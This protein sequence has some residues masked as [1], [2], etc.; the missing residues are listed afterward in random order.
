MAAMRK[1]D[2]TTEQLVCVEY[3]GHDTLFIEAPGSG[4]SFVLSFRGHAHGRTAG[5]TVQFATFTNAVARAA[6]EMDQDVAREEP[7]GAERIRLAIST[8]DTAVLTHRTDGVIPLDPA[9]YHAELSPAD[10]EEFLSFE[11]TLLYVAITRARHMLAM[12]CF[13]TPSRFL[14]EVGPATYEIGTLPSLRERLFVRTKPPVRRDR[15]LIEVN[16]R[17]GVWLDT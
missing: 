14:Q 7:A 4:K 12:T 5:E 1:A 6:K 11:R 10:E 17:A 16:R 15:F 9:R 8:F 13:G 2:L 3:L